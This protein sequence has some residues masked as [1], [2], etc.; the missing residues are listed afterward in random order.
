MNIL[1]NQKKIKKTLNQIKSFCDYS[2]YVETSTYKC[3]SEMPQ[4]LSSKLGN[5]DYAKQIVTFWYLSKL[6]EDEYISLDD[7]VKFIKADKDTFINQ[8]SILFD[9]YLKNDYFR[10]YLNGFIFPAATGTPGEESVSK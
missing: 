10:S 2:D 1:K 4:E 6:I 8:E 7:Y 3:C 5:D 9:Y